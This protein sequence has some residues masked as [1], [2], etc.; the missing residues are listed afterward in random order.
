MPHEFS[1]HA[2]TSNILAILQ[3]HFGDDAERVLSRS[4]LLQ[5]LNLKTKSANRG[6]KAR[7]SFASHYALYVVVEDYINHGY[8]DGSADGL[9][10]A[11]EGARFS[12]LSKRQPTAFRLQI[13]ESRPQC[14]GE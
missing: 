7:G 14:P 8:A 9:Y 6:S 2:F 11:Y 10:S 1:C 3:K 13:A 4:P 5:Y 12:D